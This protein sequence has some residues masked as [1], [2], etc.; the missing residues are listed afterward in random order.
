MTGT[1]WAATSVKA[2]HYDQ[3]IV[4]YIVGRSRLSKVVS[5]ACSSL[6][7]D[8]LPVQGIVIVFHIVSRDIL[9]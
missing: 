8:V 7:G 5:Y 1:V 9:L 2:L 4:G 3:H 6:D